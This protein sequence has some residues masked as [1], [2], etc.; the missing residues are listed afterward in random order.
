MPHRLSKI[1]RFEAA[2]FLSRVPPDHPCRRIH[3]HSYE[4]TVTVQG[5]VDPATGWFMDYKEM[6]RVVRAVLDPLDH[7]FLNAM[8]GLEN[9]TSE[10]LA[11]WIWER[12]A[13]GLPG[14]KRVRVKETPASICD[15]SGP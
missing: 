7:G 15:Y 1:F 8:P 11:V 2:H 10:I 9:P 14:L 12:L 6:S 4:V 13:P 5:D 3:G